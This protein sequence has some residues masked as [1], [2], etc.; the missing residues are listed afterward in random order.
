MPQNLVLHVAPLPLVPAAIVVL[1][2][3]EGMPPRGPAAEMREIF[4]QLDEVLAK[5]RLSR[6]SVVSV[7]LYLAQVNRDIAAVNEVYKDYF[8]GCTPMRM[9][10]GAELQKGMLVEAQFIAEASPS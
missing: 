10:V 6:K 7:R 2:T 3:A 1:Y 5:A 8:T 4:R 9:A